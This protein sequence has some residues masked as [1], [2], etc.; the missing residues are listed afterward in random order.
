MLA[1]AVTNA[2][3]KVARMQLHKYAT[4]DNVGHIPANVG[5][6]LF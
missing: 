6:L 5:Q 2:V 4:G 3:G 1:L